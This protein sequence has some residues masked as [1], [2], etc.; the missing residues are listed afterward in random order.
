MEIIKE[1]IVM[2]TDYDVIIAG[3]GTGGATTAY[4]LAKRGHAVLFIDRKERYNIGN[5]N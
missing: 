3:A 5:K 4:A 2:A 1:V